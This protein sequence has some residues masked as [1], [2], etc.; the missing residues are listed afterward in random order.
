MPT[1]KRF[2]LRDTNTTGL[3]KTQIYAKILT[4]TGSL[5]SSQVVATVVRLWT[6]ELLAAA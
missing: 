5:D 6:A 3:T 2:E 4:T 1:A